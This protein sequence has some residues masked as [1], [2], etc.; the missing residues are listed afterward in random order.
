MISTEKGVLM[1]RKDGWHAFIELCQKAAKQDNLPKVYQFIFTPE[2]REQLAT[3]TLLI[4][5]LLEGALSQREISAKLKVSISKITRG[6]NAL[7]MIDENLK[8]FLKKT[9]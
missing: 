4:K 1:E 7:K 5:A 2:E 8:K 3:R 9:L 6:S